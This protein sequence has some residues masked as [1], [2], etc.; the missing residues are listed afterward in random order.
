MIV[1]DLDGTLALDDHRRHFLLPQE[2]GEK[3][4]DSY[5]AA[6]G[7]DAPAKPIIHLLRRLHGTDRIVLWSGRSDSV[8]EQTEIWLAQHGLL[9]LFDEVR[10]R[11]ADDR[12]AD[13]ELKRR[14]LNEAR[15]NGLVVE[16]VFEDRQRVVDMWRAE[17][18]VCCQVAP[19]DF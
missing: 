4:W 17:G 6:C 12:T 7:G 9:A 8:R 18:I 2:G 3:D 15:A 1:F 19:G 14:W 5:F 10:L 13:D 11:E 16:L